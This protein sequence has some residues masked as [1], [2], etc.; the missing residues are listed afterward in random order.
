MSGFGGI[1]RRHLN[2]NQR[3]MVAR[4]L[5]NMRHGGDRTSEES[6]RSIDLLLPEISISQAAAMLK[7]DYGGK[8]VWPCPVSSLSGL[9]RGI[10]TGGMHGRIERIMAPHKPNPTKMTA[11]ITELLAGKTIPQASVSTGIPVSTLYRWQ[12][13]SAF[14]AELALMRR[15]TIRASLDFLSAGARAASGEILS[16]MRDKDNPPSVR[17]RAACEVLDRLT[18]WAELED[19]EN[20][21]KMLEDAAGG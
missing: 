18:K 4:K 2:E 14:I 7:P 20:R 10:P 15:E 11:V 17:L 3:G 16:V 1:A 9:P 8:D 19:L 6:K 12:R 21:I 5:A 13:D